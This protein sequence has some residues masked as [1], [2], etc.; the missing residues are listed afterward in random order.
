[1]EL[2]LAHSLADRVFHLYWEQGFEERTGIKLLSPFYEVHREDIEALDAGGKIEASSD[3]IVLAD[4][5]AIQRTEG[6]VACVNKYTSIGT[7]MKICYAYTIYGLPVYVI[8]TDDR[9]KHPWLVY[10]STEIFTSYEDFEEWI[11]CSIDM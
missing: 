1:M 5:E 10:H 9:A 7:I 8:C 3:D 2:Y 11:T 6:I 4:L